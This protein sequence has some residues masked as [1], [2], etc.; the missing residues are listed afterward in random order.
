MGLFKAYDCIPHD[1][2]IAKLEAY[3]LD[4]CALKLVYT[5]LTNQ[6]QRVK[7]GSAYSNFQS[8]STGVPQGS[9]LSPL[10]FNIFINDLL[11]TDLESEICN[12]ADDQG[13][14]QLCLRRGAKNQNFPT[15][16][17]STTTATTT[18]VPI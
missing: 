9:V 7:V 13:R 17:P 2:L 11:F 16:K 5:Y 18:V 6:K 14:Y 12:F 15:K 4:T 10:L 8:I 3:G 1:L